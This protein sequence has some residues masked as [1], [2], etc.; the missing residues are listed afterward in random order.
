MA[1]AFGALLL[2]YALVMGFW[3][4]RNLVVF[5]S[6]FP[7]GSSRAMWISSYDQ[8]YAF[9]ASALNLQNWLAAGLPAL[10]AQ[11]WDALVANLQTALAVQGAVFLTPLILIGLW[12]LRKSAV[13]QIGVAVWLVTFL[14]MTLVF[15]LAGARGGFLHS[16]AAFQ[17]LLWAAAAEGLLAFIDLGVRWRNW[18]V[19][20]ALPGFGI[21]AVLIAALLT[22]GVTAS[23]VIA[24]DGPQSG[25]SASWNQYTAVDQA[26]D[27][28]AVPADQV[29]MVNNPPGFFIASGRPAIV[30]PNG[31]VET[32]LAAAH[33]YHGAYLV[34]EEN[35]VQGLLPLVQA[36]RRRARPEVY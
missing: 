26:L 1:A 19:E 21:I 20:R 2:A 7:G 8:L 12:R 15:P 22:L 24:S 29:V 17:P 4:G 28:L 16:G 6:L 34:L 33:K 36:A 25:W 5:G 35:T 11:R 27:A 9:P 14:I 10:V 13:V 32:L 30:I 3:F 31:G 18:K 23:R